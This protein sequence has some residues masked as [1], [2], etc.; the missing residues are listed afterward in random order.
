MSKYNRVKKIDRLNITGGNLVEIE[1]FKNNR[2]TTFYFKNNDNIVDL[3]SFLNSS[4]F[5]LKLKLKE[6]C[7]SS[8]YKFNLWVD[9]VYENTITG[10]I[11][12]VS[13]KTTNVVC[14]LTSNLSAL[15]K[16]M[17][18]KLLNEQETFTLKGS[19]WR[20]ISL[21]GLQLRTNKVNLLGGSTFIKLPKIIY[22]KKA[23]INVKNYDNKCFKYAILSK[24]NEKKI[25]T[26]L[27]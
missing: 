14:F 17:F 16:N 15:L 3:L 6:L 8:S 7:K 26:I 1:K 25:K 21:D 20:Q 23:I 2:S 5:F 18:D 10:E 11:R 24:F 12:D 4:S 9:L 13:F 22:N 27:V 19:S